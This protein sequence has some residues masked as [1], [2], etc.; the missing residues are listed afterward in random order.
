MDTYAY[1]IREP[2]WPSD[3]FLP[4]VVDP[5]EFEQAMAPHAAFEK[6]VADLG[7]RITGGAALAQATYGGLTTP[8][9]EGHEVDQAVHTDS[10][11][12]DSSDLITGFYLVEVEDEE[13]ARRISAMV[14]TGGTVEWRKLFPMD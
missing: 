3:D 9:P 8:G 4:G 11:Y 12:V 2:D 5:Q 1:L 13:T 14:P 6:A 7:A 10:P